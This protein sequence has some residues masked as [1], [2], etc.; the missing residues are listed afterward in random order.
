MGLIIVFVILIILSGFFSSSETALFSLD[1]ARLRTLVKQ[2][3]RGAKI[4]AYLRKNP[5]RLI[6]TILIGNNIVNIAA[7]VLATT[8]GIK[9]FGSKGVGIAFGLTTFLILLFGE[10]LPKSMAAS[11]P[12]AISLSV[13]GPLKIIGWV[14]WPI[15]FLFEKA[16][17]IVGPGEK[18]QITE[19]EI[20]AIAEMGVEAGT[21]EK[22]EEEIIEKAFRFTDITADDVMTPR[23]KMFRLNGELTLEDA[24]GAIR[25]AP[26]SRIPVFEKV[27][28]NITGILYAKDILN[29]PFEK[30]SQI[31]VRDI[32]KE[33]YFIPEQKP[34]DDLLKEFQGR[35]AHIA[36]VVNEYGEVVGLV[37]L[38]D[39]IEELLGEI[40]DEKDVNR[41]LIKRIAKNA[42]LV[43]GATEIGKINDFF[44]IE[45]PGKETYTI[46]SLVFEKLGRIPPPGEKL[47][48]DN[49][50]LEIAE[51]TKKTILKVKISK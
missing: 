1:K 18:H 20:R 46:T 19:E 40:I 50:E 12:T 27:P 14:L 4:L 6:I 26:Y 29:Y 17:K 49:L 41:I 34:V 30:L 32:V 38:E 13:G 48:I 35:A 39:L 8:I 9:Y 28:E 23:T 3:V 5:R 15:I 37:T 11:R 7:S 45:L 10:I 2:K 21:I 24:I 47:K 44:N 36:I 25:Q 22:K 33:P 31:Y 43:D 51:A 16:A 42:I